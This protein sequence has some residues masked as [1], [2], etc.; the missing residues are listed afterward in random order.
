MKLRKRNLLALLAGSLLPISVY[1]QTAWSSEPTE[2]PVNVILM[3]GDGMGLAQVSAALYTNYNE[4]NLEKLPVLGFHKS[5]SHDQLVTD[6]AAGATAFSCGCKT[7]NSAIGL[8]PDSTPCTTILE[9]A[10]TRGLATGLIVTSTIVHATPASFAAHSI[11]REFYDDIAVDMADAGID[12]MIG[13]GR[14]YFN[15]RSSDD[16]DLIAEMKAKGYVVE[17]YLNNTLDGFKWE[18]LRPL[19][20]FTADK[21]PLNVAAGRD[22]LSLATKLGSEFLLK[23]SSKGFFLM[24][25]GSQI[26]WACHAKDGKLAIKETLDFDRA[27]GVALAFAQNHPNTLLIVTAD[28]ETGGLALAPDSKMGR[29]ETAFTTNNHTASLIPVYAFGPG[30]RQFSGIYENTDIYTKIRRI[31]GFPPIQSKQEPGNQPATHSEN[32]GKTEPK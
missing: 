16:R 12:L 22:Y 30:S 15:R 7:F 31:L 25:E 27:V 10:H 26:D 32:T 24:I 1:T 11:S 18:P 23:K 17:D 29:V 13:G 21:Q 20:Y 28:H 3:I 6:S 2:T 19:V 4:L 5:Y 8:K 9:E 14:Q